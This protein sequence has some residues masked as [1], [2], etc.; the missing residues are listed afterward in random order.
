MYIMHTYQR[1]VPLPYRGFQ[2]EEFIDKFMS[3]Q[4]F[5]R[6]ILKDLFSSASTSR[7]GISEGKI[8]GTLEQSIHLQTAVWPSR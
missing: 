4:S 7:S 8:Q 1:G 5:Y 2:Q 6:I 3:K